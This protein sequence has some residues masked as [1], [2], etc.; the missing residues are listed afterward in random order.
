MIDICEWYLNWYSA[1]F[2]EV[3]Q[4]L[5]NLPRHALPLKNCQLVILVKK[6]TFGQQWDFWWKKEKF[7]IALLKWSFILPQWHCV[8]VIVILACQ[9]MHLDLYISYERRNV[10]MRGC[11]KKSWHF[12]VRTKLLECFLMGGLHFSNQL[13]LS[14]FRSNLVFAS[15]IKLYGIES[16][17]V[18]STNGDHF[19][20]D[21]LHLRW[22]F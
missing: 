12:I 7:T 2:F 10:A 20:T 18:F 11:D 21:L 13:Q 22:R 15:E 4:V 9:D 1:D 19:C 16:P 8:T 17:Q 5:V 14:R 3:V 6:R